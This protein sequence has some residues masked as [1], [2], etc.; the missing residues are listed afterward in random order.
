M[1]DAE[2]QLIL[3]NLHLL[4]A[5][6]ILYISNVNEQEIISKTRSPLVQKLFD[7]AEKEGNNA[8]RICGQIEQEISSLPEEEKQEFSKL[9]PSA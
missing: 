9:L 4:T 3:K 7:F 5:K 1:K 2:E 8:I 6:P